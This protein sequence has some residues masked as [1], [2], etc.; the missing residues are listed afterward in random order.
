MKIDFFIEEDNYI[1][2]EFRTCKLIKYQNGQMSIFFGLN[3]ES[4]NIT[5]IEDEFGNIIE[6]LK[7][8][9]NII[10]FI[11]SVDEVKTTYFVFKDNITSFQL[12]KKTNKL[13]I[14]L[15]N[16]DFSFQI[17]LADN[18]DIIEK[19]LKE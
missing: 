9:F 17:E 2:V 3:D 1:S 13:S 18:C 15:D 6:H 10:D 4:Q 5:I 7:T 16:L 8:Q 14:S 12:N 11:S 19:S